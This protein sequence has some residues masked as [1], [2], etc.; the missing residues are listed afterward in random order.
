MPDTENIPYI[1]WE[2]EKAREE[3]RHKR[4][5]IIKIVLIV[6][7]F[8]SNALWLYAWSQY[9]YSGY[10]EEITIDGGERGFA[11]YIG[12]DGEIN[13]GEDNS[14]EEND[15]TQEERWNR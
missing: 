6:M 13:Y 12:H 10:E 3:R 4:D 14:E 9:D 5:F 7:L 8:L 2:G 11:G 1:V 15:G